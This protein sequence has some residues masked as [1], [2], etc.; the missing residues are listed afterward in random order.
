[1][2]INAYVLAQ[3]RAVAPPCARHRQR[4]A[5]RICDSGTPAAGADRRPGLLGGH[6]RLQ[7]RSRQAAPQ[8]RRLSRIRTGE[9]DHRR[10]GGFQADRRLPT[11]YPA[12]G[13]PCA[14][15]RPRGGHRRQCAGGDLRRARKPRR[16]FSARAGHDALRRGQLHQS[17]HRQAAGPLGS[18]GRRAASKR[19]P[20]PKAATSPRRRA[21]RSTLIA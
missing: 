16:L 8:P 4:A 7:R 20:T 6:A 17:R 3:P 11:R 21:T 5:S 12:R 18:R 10:R 13:H 19:K 9:L 14:V 2:E 1:M 15:V